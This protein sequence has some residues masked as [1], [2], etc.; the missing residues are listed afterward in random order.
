MCTACYPGSDKFVHNYTK[1]DKFTT[2]TQVSVW[3][4]FNVPPE[5]APTY[6]TVGNF[7]GGNVYSTLHRSESIKYWNNTEKQL[8]KCY[9]LEDEVEVHSVPRQ[10]LQN[11]QRHGDMLYDSFSWTWQRCC[12]KQH[13]NI[14]IN[15]FL[16][17]HSSDSKKCFMRNWPQ[18]ITHTCYCTC[19]ILSMLL[20]HLLTICFHLVSVSSCQFYVFRA[21]YS[22]VP[23]WSHCPVRCMWLQ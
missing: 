16:K 21:V 12:N 6:Y 10:I 15:L 19:S 3:V 2:V 20:F 5:N 23:L 9:H 18:F 22:T 14:L 17:N 8:R 4:E 11:L 13:Y 1:V 7:R